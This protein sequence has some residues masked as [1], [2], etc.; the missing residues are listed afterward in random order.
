MGRSLSKKRPWL[1]VLLTVLATG[2]GHVYL[3]RWRRAFGWLAVAFVTSYLLVPASAL[4][5]FVAGGAVAWLDLLPLLVVSVL[6]ALDAYQLAV[7]DNSLHRVHTHDGDGPTV[8]PS[9]GRPADD[10]LDFCQWCA[11]PLAGETG[12]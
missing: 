1:A 9:C 11:T 3:R 4:E 8:C 7:V 6:S 10:E 2:A 12:I 5:A